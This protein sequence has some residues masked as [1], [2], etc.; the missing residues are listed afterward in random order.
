[1]QIRFAGGRLRRG[2]LSERAEAGEK[3][4]SERESKHR[5]RTVPSESATAQRRWDEPPRAP[6][7]E[8]A[9]ELRRAAVRLS[10][11]APRAAGAGRPGCTRARSRRPC[12]RCCRSLK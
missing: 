2:C 10:F 5:E 3:S 1:G 4:E 6:L 8:S 12:P 7:G 9:A 11:P